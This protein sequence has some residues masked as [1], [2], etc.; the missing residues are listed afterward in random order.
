MIFLEGK[1]ICAESYEEILA[2]IQNYETET[3]SKF[4]CY[5]ADKNFGNIE[6]SV[7]HH[8]IRWE[9]DS[10]PFNGV[11]F[12]IVG[13]KVFDCMHGRD[14]KVSFKEEY[15]MR[16][17]DRKAAGISQP[18]DAR[19][20]EEIFTSSEF[21]TSVDEMRRRL[22]IIVTREIFKNSICPSKSNKRFF[23]SKKTIRSYM[24][25]A[26]RKKRYSNIDQECLI[27]KVEQW[28]VENPHRRFYLRPKGI[29]ENYAVKVECSAVESTEDEDEIVVEALSNSFLFVYQTEEMQRLLKIYGNEIT[30]LDAT[31]K[32]TKYSLPLF[33]LV[34]KTNVDY[35]IVG[36]F[37]CEGESTKNIQSGLA[38]IKEWNPNWNPLYFMVDCCAEEINAIESL[39]QG[40][41]R[42]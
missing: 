17:N 37:I 25:E 4:S 31:Y 18:I 14:R 11:P 22:E 27:K 39:H 41:S 38:K 24:L 34:V 36:T 5:S 33:F 16:C 3:V 8:K 10:V 6:A 7:K 15:K 1:W 40:I 32:T 28:K 9:D 2:L 42:F 19:L 21:I 23:P 12:V 30:L 20:K 29:S 35:Q 13:S 26:I